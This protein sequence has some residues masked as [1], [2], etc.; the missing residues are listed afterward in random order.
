MTYKLV[1]LARRAQTVSRA[2]WP[3]T[4]KSHAV[5][6]SQFPA[7]A[8][9]IAW[10]RYCNRM[11]A[12]LPNVSQQHD[13]VAVAAGDTLEA[14]MG[15]VLSGEERAR[16]DADELRV[17]DMLTPNFTWFCHEEVLREGPLGEAALFRFRLCD[18]P[19]PL[20]EAASRIAVNRPLSARLPLFPFTTIVES[21]FASTQDAARAAAA[22][23][24]QDG[25]V[26][27]L[28]AVC[29]RWPK[30]DVVARA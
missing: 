23:A 24:P 22:L 3:R 20:A 21:W 1:Y 29:H 4:W 30:S 18:Q 25:E 5:F 15:G 2:D 12:A 27:L 6:A 28:T 14:L 10:M 17:F 13:G 26:A 8:A 9:K 11:D 7:L 16:I 19:A